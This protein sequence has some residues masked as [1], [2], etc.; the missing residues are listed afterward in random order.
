MANDIQRVL[1]KALA[2]LTKER[3]RT[4]RQIS[5]LETAL[6]AVNSRGRRAPASS[7]ARLRRKRPMSAAARK[8]IS[9]RMKA[10]W[11]KRKGAGATKK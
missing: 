3:E 5:A 8:A 7:R 9:R 11:A 4:D 1:R 2:S 10:A 6:G